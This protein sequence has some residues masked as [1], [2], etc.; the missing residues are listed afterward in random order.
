MNNEE[1][2]AGAKVVL[3]DLQEEG[4]GERTRMVGDRETLVI[5]SA[6]CYWQ[7]VPPQWGGGR[8]FD[9]STKFFYEN[10]CNSGTESRKIFPKVGN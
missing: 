2:C 7:T 4:A 10:S 5:Q 3:E 6:S 1:L 8:L 9:G